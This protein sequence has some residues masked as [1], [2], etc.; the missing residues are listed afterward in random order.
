MPPMG[1]V[2]GIQERIRYILCI[3]RAENLGVRDMEIIHAP[4]LKIRVRWNFLDLIG[5][6]KSL[7]LTYGS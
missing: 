1:P 2:L 4:T 7:K 5:T 3:Q 6:F